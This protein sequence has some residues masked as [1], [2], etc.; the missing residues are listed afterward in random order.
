MKKKYVLFSILLLVFGCIWFVKS[1]EN[2][3]SQRTH[4]NSTNRLLHLEP[5]TQAET[6]D[7]VTNQNLVDRHS[8]FPPQ[9]KLSREVEHAMTKGAQARVTLRVVDS[10]GKCVPNARVRLNFM[11]FERK[12]NFE[13]GLTDTNGMFSAER[14]TMSECNWFIEKEGY[15]NTAGMHSFVANLTNDSVKDGRWQPWNPTLEVI[16]KEKRKPIQMVVRDIS[17]NLPQKEKVG[18]DCM[19]G[20]CLP[21]YGKGETADIFFYYTSQYNG[22]WGYLT[23]SLSI[24]MVEG[25]GVVR[26]Q[27]DSFSEL[28]SLYEAPLNGY[29]KEIRCER[30]R[31]PEKIIKDMTVSKDEGLVFRSW[32]ETRQKKGGDFHYGKAHLFEYGQDYKKS[33]F[34]FVKFEY[35]FNPTPNDRNIEAEGQYP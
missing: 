5:V 18:F 12:N 2:R 23:N 27:K 31:I 13:T 17:I 10:T 25:G 15:Y 19:K 34:G 7:A 4:P 14:D 9:W 32:R 1:C 16:L 22:V 28:W 11:F 30:E 6:T 24:T 21:P 35:Y 3:K 20:E 8:I 26:H 33:G 29:Q